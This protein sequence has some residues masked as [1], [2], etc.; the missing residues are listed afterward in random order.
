MELLN[1]ISEKLQKGKA[2]EV[3][4][5]VQQAVDEGIEPK[6]ILEEGLLPG[7]SEIG[8]KFKHGQNVANAFL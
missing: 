3:K 6:K 5:L 4:A 2:K 8:E 1:L 7:M